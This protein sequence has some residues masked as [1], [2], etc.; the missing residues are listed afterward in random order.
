MNWRAG[1][2]AVD[3]G[4]T[5]RRAYRIENGAVPTQFEDE[6]GLKAVPEGGFP[7]AA[8][9]IREQLG[10]LPMLLA[11][12]VGSSKGWREAPYVPCPARSAELAANIVWIDERTGIVPGVC[13]RGPAGADVMR[14]EEVQILGA[15][16]AGL[17]PRDALVCHP[18]THAKWIEVKHGDIHSFRTMMTGEVFG[19]LGQHSILADL[20]AG[21]ASVGS[22]F[23]AGV[24]G[25]LEGEPPLSALFRI[26]SRYLLENDTEDAASRASG[27]LIGSEVAWA[28]LAFAHSPIALIGRPELCELYAAALRLAGRE[29]FMVDGA[30]A[31]LAGIEE[32]TR[33]L[34]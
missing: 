34:P 33:M 32:L 8:A 6:L 2:I 12:M 14:G 4:T 23:E 3:W 28:T 17:I 15:V 24:A 26:R 10:D 31:F 29:T 25:S 13:Q 7:A 16:V 30:E 11:G 20:L 18:G 22:A 27:I 5:N 1:Y 21:D 19:L 9:H